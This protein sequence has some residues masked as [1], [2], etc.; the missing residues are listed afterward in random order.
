MAF[1][2]ILHSGSF[3][4]YNGDE[5]KVT[6]YRRVDLN[7]SP[8]SLTFYVDGGTGTLS[9]W[10][11]VGDAELGDP[12]VDWLHWGPATNREKLVGCDYY[13]YTYEITC[14]PNNSGEDRT[15]ELSVDIEGMGGVIITVPVIQYNSEQD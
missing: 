1:E 5:I 9:I 11:R 4:D 10:S 7:A 13:K 12:Q 3:N 6:F 8:T 2:T 15:T 14:D